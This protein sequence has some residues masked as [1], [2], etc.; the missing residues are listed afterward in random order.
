MF[1]A[2]KPWYKH[3]AITNTLRLAVTILLIWL[4]SKR[5]N[6][7]EIAAIFRTAAPGWLASAILV[8]ALSLIVSSHRSAIYLSGIGI[9]LKPWSALGLY[10]KGTVYNVL[11]PGGIGGDGYKILVLRSKDGPSVKQIFQ[12]FF[13]E[14][15]SGLWAICTLLCI[16]NTTLTEPILPPVWPGLV[17]VI[18]TM[19]Y[20][21]IMR[22]FFSEHARFF[23]RTHLMSLGIQGMVSVAVLC[24]LESQPI[25]VSYPPYLLSFHGSTIFSILNIG[26]SGLGVREFA[27][28]YAAQL[29]QNNAAL[30][31]FV[32]S[33]FWLVSTT[34]AIPGLG[35]LFIGGKKHV[36]EGR[37]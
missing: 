10:M 3:A 4:V 19:G 28:G 17:W 12:A 9:L 6:L 7:R 15:L 8:Y 25:P 5:V 31:V 29:L 26:L 20:Y 30:S 18:G 22:L 37:D 1:V 23:L 35:F 13:F 16:L 34:T 14:R 11:L 27:M 24:I 21:I 36:D 2:M 32:A 33:A